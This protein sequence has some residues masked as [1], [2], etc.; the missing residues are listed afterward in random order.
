MECNAFFNAWA[1]A[2]SVRAAAALKCV[3]TFDH[4]GSIGDRSG[5]YGGRYTS[6]HPSAGRIAALYLFFD[7]LP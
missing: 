2:S 7:K 3:F 5:E 1:T 6:L 4:I